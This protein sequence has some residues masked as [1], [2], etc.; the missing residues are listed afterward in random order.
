MRSKDNFDLKVKGVGEL[1]NSLDKIEKSIVDNAEEILKDAAQI[2]LK[3]A[4]NKVP[5]DTGDLKKSLEI[6]TLEIKANKLRIGVGPVGDDQFYWFW[7]EHGIKSRP[8]YPAQPFLR[9][10]FDGNK[11]KVKAEIAKNLKLL[12]ERRGK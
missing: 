3:S 9:P 11:G 1:F 7:V 12:V 5:V 2:F 6:K 4:K 10:A 8:G